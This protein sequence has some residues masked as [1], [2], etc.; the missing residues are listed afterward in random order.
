[1]LAKLRLELVPQHEEKLPP[2]P[3]FDLNLDSK[4]KADAVREDARQAGLVFSRLALAADLGPDDCIVIV[5]D[6]P[7]SEWSRRRSPKDA[8]PTSPDSAPRNESQ[9]GPA[10]PPAPLEATLG[11]ALLTDTFDTR[12]GRKLVVILLPGVP[13]RFELLR[14]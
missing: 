10:G 4:A 6:S 2:R 14:K 3:A 13:D 12:R 5:P 11:E 8:D 1:M 7:T 9:F